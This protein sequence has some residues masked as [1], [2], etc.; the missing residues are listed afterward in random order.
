MATPH[1]IQ[2]T[3]LSTVST[4]VVTRLLIFILFHADLGPEGNSNFMSAIALLDHTNG[5]KTYKSM[6]V[7]GLNTVMRLNTTTN[8]SV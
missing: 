7:G 2:A 4:G 3:E 1:T 5:T 6:V 8:F